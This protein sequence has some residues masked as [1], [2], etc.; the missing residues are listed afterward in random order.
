[1]SSSAHKGILIVFE[2]IDGSGKSTQLQLLAQFLKQQGHHVITTREPTDGPFGRKLRSLFS[3]RDSMTREE[4]LDLFLADRNDHVNRLLAPSLD[5]GKIV[6]CDRYFL[7]TVAYQGAVGFNPDE[8]LAK[9]DFAPRPDL[10]LIFTTTP[11]NGIGRIT[12]GRGEKLND[13]E[14]ESTLT[15]VAAIFDTLDL[16]Y[17][18][19]IDADCTIEEVQRQ[20]L[21]SVQDLLNDR[22]SLLRP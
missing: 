15:Q 1:M 6:L 22:A 9:N 2:G 8:I 11:Q 14:Q 18:K 10:A 16:P 20:V 13:F 12:N 17:I 4:E 3:Q 5:Q 19:R 21:T 7:S